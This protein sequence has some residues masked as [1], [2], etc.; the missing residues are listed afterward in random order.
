MKS[1]HCHFFRIISHVLCGMINSFHFVEN[2]ESSEI[3]IATVLA[4]LADRWIARITKA[5]IV[6]SDHVPW[7]KL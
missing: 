1:R 6:P 3:C 2:M 4:A 5:R 7:D